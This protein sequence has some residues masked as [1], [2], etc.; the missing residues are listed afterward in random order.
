LKAKE[1]DLPVASIESESQREKKL[2]DEELG[3]TRVDRRQRSGSAESFRSSTSSE[4]EQTA[5]PGAVAIGGKA[6]HA[7]A[8][9]KDSLDDDVA[10]D[11]HAVDDE[12]E[13]SCLLDGA[14]QKLREKIIS[15]AVE[16]QVLEKK[17]NIHMLCLAATVCALVVAAI[18]TAVLVDADR[19]DTNGAVPLVDA[20]GPDAPTNNTGEPQQDNEPTENL[21]F[22]D[23]ESKCWT[24]LGD[25]VTGFLTGDEF[26]SVLSLSETGT[27][28]AVG[29]IYMD[30]HFGA[31]SGVIT[32]YE[33][34]ANGVIAKVGQDVQGEYVNAQIAPALSGDGNRLVAS[35]MG[36]AVDFQVKPTLWIFMS[37]H[38]MS[39]L[40]LV[41]PCTASQNMK[42]SPP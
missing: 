31:R 24:R 32:V 18:I 29:A 26:G 36:G 21:T 6:R 42:S 33:I 34:G 19:S 4:D 10:I 40:R 12:A 28:M 37:M 1:M 15:E 30:G 17:S 14:E 9:M 8:N 16:A 5:A 25:Y 38:L 2:E 27:R 41:L 3:G 11:A 20:I 13:R 22:C 23:E 7:D 35:S 39:G